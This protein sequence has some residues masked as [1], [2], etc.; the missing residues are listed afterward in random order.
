MSLPPLEIG[1]NYLVMMREPQSPVVVVALPNQDS[2]ELDVEETLTYLKLM[3]V[4]EEVGFFDY[5]WN[6]Y[7]AK[8]DLNI[9]HFE[10]LTLEQASSYIRKPEEVSF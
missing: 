4:S 8:L 3:N 5:V 9:M 1:G 10:P 7:A 2:Y 6:F